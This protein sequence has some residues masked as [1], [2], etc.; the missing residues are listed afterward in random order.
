MFILTNDIEMV[1]KL[2]ALNYP[3]IRKTERDGNTIYCF[4]DINRLIFSYE[5]KK[6]IVYSNK[7]FF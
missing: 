4:K 3:V 2:M 7:L 1:N 5:E 6:K